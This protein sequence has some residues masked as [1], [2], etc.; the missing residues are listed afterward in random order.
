MENTDILIN[1]EEEVWETCIDYPCYEVSNY[2]LV[3]NKKSKRILIS[4][5]HIHSSNLY[6]RVCLKKGLPPGGKTV[7]C[8]QLV[9]KAFVPN[10]DPTK[11]IVD[12]IDRNRENNFYKNLR[13]VDNMENTHN[14]RQ[15]GKKVSRNK[16]PIVL[17]EKET[18]NLINS[19]NNL[20]EA[21]NL[22]GIS[23]ESIRLNIHK[24]TEYKDKQFLTEKQYKELK[25]I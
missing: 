24:R 17:V 21:S 5:Q 12:H 13:W 9:A 15:R 4:S 14:S 2:G 20:I 23:E 19:F 16:T 3:R 7:A 8:H 18:L 25:K 22:T 11:T 10:T 6:K 1:K